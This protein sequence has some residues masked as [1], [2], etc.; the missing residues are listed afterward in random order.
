M[1]KTDANTQTIVTTLDELVDAL[2]VAPLGAHIIVE[3]DDEHMRGVL[4]GGAER[5][6]APWVCWARDERETWHAIAKRASAMRAR[7]RA[8]RQ[9]RAA[10]AME[11]AEIGADAMQ[12]ALA[13]VCDA[14]A[15]DGDS[16][17]DV[18]AR[19][20]I[21]LAGRRVVALCDAAER[22]LA[23]ALDAVRWHCA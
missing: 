8:A 1:P 16:D 9:R 10:R 4:V 18:L 13:I 7:R 11:V 19:L 17:A 2:A 15:Q 6:A 20:G 12:R 14:Y 5:G 23:D 21:E 22:V 3:H